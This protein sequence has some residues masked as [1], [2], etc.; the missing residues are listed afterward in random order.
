AECLGAIEKA[1]HRVVAYSWIQ[2]SKEPT[3]FTFQDGFTWL[4]FVVTLEVLCDLDLVPE[5]DSDSPCLPTGCTMSDVICINDND[6]DK[7]Y[8]EAD[9]S[10]DDTDH[11]ELVLPANFFV[12]D[13]VAAFSACDKAHCSGCSVGE[14]FTGLFGVPFWHT[15]FYKNRK[16]WNDACQSLH[17]KSLAA[18][19]TSEGQWSMFLKVSRAHTPKAAK[20]LLQFSL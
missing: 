5:E 11:R 14:T 12:V 3:V 19:K 9:N 10:G 15:T 13:I 7:H 20:K 1:K 16:Q 8:L 18:G 4:H 6:G 2:N 17:D